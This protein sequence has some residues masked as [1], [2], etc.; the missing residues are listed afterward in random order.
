[1]DQ[2]VSEHE[3]AETLKEFIREQ[4][5]KSWNATRSSKAKEK[6]HN[7]ERSKPYGPMVNLPISAPKQVRL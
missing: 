4:V 5:R 7:E 3:I 1:M 6:K 2:N